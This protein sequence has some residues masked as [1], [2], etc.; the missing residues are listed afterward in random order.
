M[1]IDVT[2]FTKLPKFD[3]QTDCMLVCVC[4]NTDSPDELYYSLKEVFL[5]RIM[6]CK[7][8]EEIISYAQI[9]HL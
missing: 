3:I 8:D 7:E 4:I 1:R 5:G 2:K 9:E 6:D